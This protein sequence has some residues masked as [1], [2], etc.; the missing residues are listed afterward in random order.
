MK[1]LETQRAPL[2][3]G[4]AAIEQWQFDIFKGAGAPE[5]IVTLKHEAE[6]VPAQQGPLVLVERANIDAFEQIGP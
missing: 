2:R 5:Q 1:R 4:N 3:C 6:I